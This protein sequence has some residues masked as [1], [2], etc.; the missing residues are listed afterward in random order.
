MKRKRM[1]EAEVR[2]YWRVD[3]PVCYETHLFDSEAGLRQWVVQ[4]LE[5]TMRWRWASWLRVIDKE[6]K[7]RFDERPLTLLTVNLDLTKSASRIAETTRWG[8]VDRSRGH[9]PYPNRM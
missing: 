3:G 9:V 4:L 5:S 1:H 7:D 8:R 6:R 2:F